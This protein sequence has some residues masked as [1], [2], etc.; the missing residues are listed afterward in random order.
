MGLYVEINGGD[1]VDV[2]Y[3]DT[4]VT[5][6][7][8][9]LAIQDGSDVTGGGIHHEGD[10]LQIKD[11][12]I[13]D[14]TSILFGG[15]IYNNS[16][17]EIID[18]NLY[19][20]TTP[21]YGGAIHNTENGVLT[22]TDTWFHSNSAAEDGGAIYN[23]GGTI[24]ISGSNFYGNSTTSVTSGDGGAVAN[25]G[26]TITISDSFFDWNSAAYSGGAIFSEEG[27][28]S[29]TNSEF[30]NQNAYNSDGGAI[31]IYASGGIVG[32]LF[33]ACTFKS[34]QADNHGGALH[35]DTVQITRIKNSTFFDNTANKGGGVWNDSNLT[36]TNN[37]FSGN[38]ARYSSDGSAVHNWQYILNLNNNILANSGTGWD[39]VNEGTVND[40]NNLI[41]ANDPNNRCGIP[42]ITA[43]PMLAPLG[44]YGG[45]TETFDLL[46]GS[47]AINAGDDA[48]CTATDQR[49]VQRPV[50]SHC[51]IGSV[52][53]AYFVYL[54][55]IMR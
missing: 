24:T 26:G 29:V 31:F 23:L 38:T 12:W 9:H 42:L 8:E 11:C 43:D 15:A 20:N 1:T 51:D 33:T 49:G 25:N 14:N 55:L 39:C 5:A 30:R 21:S 19:E 46:P 17:L 40:T 32:S 4:G 3:I 34:N 18:S 53:K 48:T 13:R 45:P 6:Y 36:L 35:V 54:P 2:F 52:E 50:G 22:I 7:F 27:N 44:D 47:P 16:E 28:I 41:E 10:F 37:T